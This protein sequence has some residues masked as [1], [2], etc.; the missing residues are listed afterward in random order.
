VS[1]WISVL[2]KYKTLNVVIVGRSKYL[3]S[4][5]NPILAEQLYMTPE[6]DYASDTKI[7]MH[8]FNIF[9]LLKSYYSATFTEIFVKSLSFS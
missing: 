6:Q 9:S 8:Q 4:T 7:F 3:S 1:L 5:V 2:A